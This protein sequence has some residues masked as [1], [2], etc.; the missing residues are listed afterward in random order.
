MTTFSASLTNCTLL[1]PQSRDSS[2]NVS[3]AKCPARPTHLPLLHR[4]D[5]TDHP[6]TQ[7]WPGGMLVVFWLPMYHEQERVRKNA[8]IVPPSLRVQ[9]KQTDLRA[10]DVVHCPHVCYE[11]RLASCSY[12]WGLRPETLW[13][14]SDHS[15]ACAVFIATV[16]FMCTSTHSPAV[17]SGDSW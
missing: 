4:V 11:P 2:P 7:E 13:N 3:E 5:N 8:G 17:F 14:H 6:V 12:A 16:M 1:L 9:K 15:S 10:H